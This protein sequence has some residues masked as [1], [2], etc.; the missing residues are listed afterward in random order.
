MTVGYVV[1]AAGSAKRFGSQKLHA[2]LGGSSLIARA[3][4][5]V[6]EGAPAC[7]VTGDPEILRM[8]HARGMATA[9]NDRPAE[10]ISRSV[11]L[12]VEAMAECDAICFLVADQPLLRRESVA[13]LAQAW[14]LEPENIL[15]AAN[16]G[17]PGNPCIFPRR[18]YPELRALS[19][20]RGG[21]AVIKNHPGDVRYYALPA[22]ELADCD[23]PE[24]LAILAGKEATP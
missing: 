9:R 15:R 11:R 21:S 22:R 24:A 17:R 12:G 1:L 10:G 16:A 2:I 13:R 4:D 19:G 6:P 23:T 3:L 8:A 5:A 7:V 20:D 18:F 14:A